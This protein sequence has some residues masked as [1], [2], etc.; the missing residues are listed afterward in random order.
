MMDPLEFHVS[1]CPFIT[2]A[3]S[4]YMFWLSAAQGWEDKEVERSIV[5]HFPSLQCSHQAK[6]DPWKNSKKI[7][8]THMPLCWARAGENNSWFTAALWTWITG[9]INKKIMKGQ[10]IFPLWKKN[11]KATKSTPL[12][13][14]KQRQNPPTPKKVCLWQYTHLFS[15]MVSE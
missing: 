4:T 3:I 6:R 14:K 11:I 8:K 9:G 1:T 2:T 13:K 12:K 5:N 10:P 7:N 15:W